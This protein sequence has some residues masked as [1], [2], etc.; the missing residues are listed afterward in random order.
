M[1]HASTSAGAMTP[2]QSMMDD[3]RRPC[4]TAWV[5]G[6]AGILSLGALVDVRLISLSLVALIIGPL[7]VMLIGKHRDEYTGLKM[8]WVGA[9]LGPLTLVGG[10]VSDQVRFRMSVPDGYQA[11]TWY[12]LEPADPRSQAIISE[13]AIELAGEKVYLRGYVYPGAARTN[14]QR[15]ILVRDSGTCC[16]GG[17]PKLTDMVVVNFVN[18]DRINY[19]WW[20]RTLGGTLKVKPPSDSQFQGVQMGAYYLEADFLK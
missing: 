10:F 19:S 18:Q 1:S 14:L 15:F 4:R 17:Q 3:F 13:K 9:L 8:A 2:D 6:V 12:D 11:L 5:A 7:G 16:F 20:P